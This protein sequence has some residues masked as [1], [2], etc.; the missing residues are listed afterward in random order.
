[1]STEAFSPKITTPTSMFT[2]GMILWDDR[3]GAWCYVKA[4]EDIAQWAV[5][6]F[7]LDSMAQ[8]ITTGRLNASSDEGTSRLGVPNVDV[9][10]DHFFWAQVYGNTKAKVAGAISNLEQYSYSSATAGAL[11]DN[12]SG[13]HRT[14]NIIFL[15]SP[16]AAGLAEVLMNWPGGVRFV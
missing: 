5:V 4:R 3:G 11:D 7:Q 6:M 13:T 12:S 10:D 1:M 15:D 9:P 14:R 16:N 2:P 8:E